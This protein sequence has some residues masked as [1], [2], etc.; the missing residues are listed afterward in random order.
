VRKKRSLAAAL[1]GLAALTAACKQPA[2]PAAVG[3]SAAVVAVPTPV[4]DSV[5]FTRSGALM[6]AHSDG[7]GAR[8]LAAPGTDQDF[9]FPSAAPDGQGYLAW[10]SSGDGRQN[11]VHVDMAGRVILLTETGE[12][13]LP[14]MKN[15][16]IGNAP[17]CSPDGKQ[18]AYSFNGNLWVMNADGYDAQT[19]IGDGASWSPAWSPDGSQVAYVNGPEG[20]LDLWVTDIDSRDT[21]QLTD[22][23]DYTVGNPRW[24]PDGQH[25]L[26]TRTR[27]E[28]SDVVEVQSKVDL[29]AADATV[30][31]KD[32]L[33]AG[34][35]FSPLGGAIVFSSSHS[36]SNTWDLYTADPFGGSVRQIT[37]GGGLSPAWTQQALEALAA[38]PT[39]RPSP[40]AAAPAPAASA[41]PAPHAAAAPASAPAPIQNA[42][43]TAAPVAS[44]PRPALSSAP[45][46]LRV[47]ASFDD[48]DKLDA[49]SLA[50]LAKLSRRVRQ[51]AGDTVVVVGPLDNSALRGL[52]FANDARSEA[53]AQQVG[54]ALVGLAG[55]KAARLKVE[56]Y[57]P[58]AAGGEADSILIYMELR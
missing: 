13:A 17:S 21:Y 6:V 50:G 49:A 36:D 43:A 22:F 52:Y 45:L 39:P 25:I 15:L 56:P 34:A 20:H 11:V 33:S 53:R 42:P 3:R 28:D 41:H 30:I 37:Q 5:A 18:I 48:Q 4:N 47:K 38:A 44:A 55:I 12:Q 32:H 9:W 57:S 7:S 58:P 23:G 54:D 35:A 46:R 29:P 16:D 24:S 8:V 51:Y 26:L 40:S 19:L 1:L 31:T 10:L 14:A 27:G 2:P